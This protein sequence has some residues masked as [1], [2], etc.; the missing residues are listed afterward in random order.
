[1]TRLQAALAIGVGLFAANVGAAAEAV[2]LA[3][4]PWPLQ[5]VRLL[6]GLFRDAQ[7]RNKAYLLRLEPDRL[8]SHVRKNAG[9]PPKGRPYGG[10]DRQGSQCVGHHL[11]ALAHMAAST[12]DPAVRERVRYIVRELAE[13]QRAAGDGSLHGYASD[14]AWYQKVSAGEMPFIPVSPWYVTH[15]IMAG[16]RDAYLLCDETAAREVLVRMA[17]WCLVVTARLTPAQWQA[18]LDRE[19]GGPH[20]VLAD[21]FAM[22]GER[23][24]L[25]L[26][27]QF[28]HHRV[29]DPLARGDASVLD[30][31]HA[32]TQ[33][34]KFIGYERI[35]EL[36]GE[37]AR[38][39][40]VLTFW[41]NVTSDRSWANGGNSQS[42][43]FFPPSEFPRK[44]LDLPGPET[45]NTYNMLRLTR[46]LFLVQPSGRLM[47]YYERALLNHVL[48]SQDPE[49]GGFAYH[50]PMRPGHYR[51]YSHPEDSFWCCVNT[52][53]ESHSQH[54]EM[55]YARAE[56]GFY[57]NLF[58]ATEAR[59]REQG[60]TLRQATRFPDEPRTTLLLTLEQ[61]RSMAL[62]LRWPAWVEAGK[63]Q[64]AVNRGRV[65]VQGTPG[66]Y[67]TL[68]RVWQS[69]DRV[70]VELPMRPRVEV[71]PRSTNYA[72]FFYGPVLLAGALSREA[73]SPADFISQDGDPIPRR[74]LPVENFPVLVAKPEKA[75]SRL[76]RM[77]GEALGFRLS[78]VMQPGDVTLVPLF[79]LHRQR[80]TVYWPVYDEPTW[81][82]A[83][84]HREAEKQEA[85]TL[86]AQTIDRVVIGD[87]D[88]ER[89]HGL[90]G[91]RTETGPAPWPHSRWRHAAGWFAYE[92]KIQPGSPA[93]LRCVF[94]GGDTGRTFDVLIDGRL[95]ETVALEAPRPGDYLVKSIP[96]PPALTAGKERMVVRFQARPGSLAGGLF[97]LRTV[98]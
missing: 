59:W 85:A 69:G 32:N 35:Y 20:E 50:T 6:E 10:W 13:C 49:T 74:A 11:S 15:K 72:A 2:R 41:E 94:W 82:K 3:A 58:I 55:I 73:L 87:A 70:Q 92:L 43:A 90:Q 93:L 9:L 64:V 86:D 26:A 17:D 56:D 12:G 80:Y 19:H 91:D 14:K 48:A 67:L 51:I 44:L 75:A 78:G 68:S 30:G 5:D 66:N 39:D 4:S 22:T 79:R 45:C 98:R 81:A 84:V 23:N 77:A 76:E 47:D 97:D 40:A 57:I 27:R 28:T 24:Y 53:M 83:R 42:E 29:Y 31:L 34:P 65:P 71:L 38:H 7:E 33:F 54:G 96:V 16:L 89:R 37:K 25:D 62:H 63:L 1:M 21:V 18:M 46:R 52:G 88:S 61:P 95:V 60:L 36:T 8:L